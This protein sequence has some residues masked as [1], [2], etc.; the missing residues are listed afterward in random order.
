[1]TGVFKSI[2]N[3]F[4]GGGG[5]SAPPPQQVGTQRVQSVADIP[6]YV[7]PYYT[8]LLDKSEELF[9]S[10]RELFPGSYTIPFSEPTQTGMDQAM[11]L[12]QAGDPLNQASTNLASQTLQG[13][14]LSNTNPYFQEAMQSAF[15]PVEARVNSI[16]SR[17]GRLGSGANQQVLTDQFARISAP[18]AMANYAQER[19]NQQEM[20]KLAPLI[21]GQ[22]F[23]DA[24]K[25]MNLGAMLEDQM[26]KQRQEEIM[27]DQFQY[28][29]PRER[30]ENQLAF[31]TGA[32]RGSTGYTD[33]PIY[34][35]RGA[36]FLNPLGGL[37]MLSGL[38][39]LFS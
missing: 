6:D 36:N 21:R 35:Q 12:A 39:G 15:D 13:N 25:Q 33:T 26:A 7:K 4:T 17:G 1:M 20:Q 9:E 31:V 29:E 34:G 3:I 11:A 23:E 37:S 19:Q 18:L 10:P 30:L 14:F 28:T 27:R 5:G 8:D 16:F 38:G 2:G 32:T 22:Q 24:Q